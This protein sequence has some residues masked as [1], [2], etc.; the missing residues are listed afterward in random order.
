MS[1]EN[2]EQVET[3]GGAGNEQEAAEAAAQ[4]AQEAAKAA[5]EGGK[6]AGASG[7]IIG[8]KAKAEEG[9]AAAAA[10][11]DW[12]DDWRKRMAGDDAKALKTLERFTDPRGVYDALREIREWR[13]SGN[14]LK[15]PGK[16]ATDEEKA[17]FA[18]AMGVPET[19]DA[20]LENLELPDGT[21]VGDADKP[22][23]KEFAEA[24]LP[25][26]ATQEQINTA[27]GW[28]FKAQEAQAAALDKADSEFQRES[29]AALRKEWGGDV[30]RNLAAAQSLFR[31]APGGME[32]EGDGLMAR[33]FG[34][35]TADGKLIGNDPDALRL[36]ASLGRELNPAVTVS[37]SADATVKGV[38]ERI[39]EIESW[40]QSS[41]TDTR[42]KYWKDDDVQKEYRDLL[43]ARTKMQERG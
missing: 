17:A 2:A 37:G 1:D 26:G 40:M 34:G 14:V 24:M 33:L 6:P 27:A 29:D 15:K 23:L 41:D 28:Y 31:D 18:K 3:E 32:V 11:A 43:D 10:P 16:D 8:G 12:P 36:F 38:S 4:A 22:A 20:Y 39:K 35:R 30:D 9:A 21:V 7:T 5:E 25:A 19:A 13:D 42:A